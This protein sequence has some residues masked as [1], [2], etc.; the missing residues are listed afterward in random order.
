MT[1]A[2]IKARQA[3]LRASFLQNLPLSGQV[4]GDS[5]TWSGCLPLA[6]VFSFSLSES[7]Y[8]NE[9]V[10]L[11]LHKRGLLAHCSHLLFYEIIYT[12]SKESLGNIPVLV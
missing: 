12:R 10:D 11:S 4:E 9:K 8:V 3:W 6:S 5:D 7:D 2:T 1:L